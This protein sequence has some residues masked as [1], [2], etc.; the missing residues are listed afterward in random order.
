MKTAYRK[1]GESGPIFILITYSKSFEFS[2]VRVWL[3]KTCRDFT[4][5]HNSRSYFRNDKLKWINGTKRFHNTY[6]FL[7]ERQRDHQELAVLIDSSI[8]HDFCLAPVCN[9]LSV[10]K[11]KAHQFPSAWWI[12]SNQ[13]K[14]RAMTSW[15]LFWLGPQAFDNLPIL[16][17]N[18]QFIITIG[19][20]TACCYA[21]GGA[22]IFSILPRVT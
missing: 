19:R 1:G 20:W 21:H 18:H 5:A 8:C 16:G 4:E 3:V 17:F 6:W 11:K 15:A 7:E 9:T 12:E 2:S 13:M 10:E 14:Y 22:Y